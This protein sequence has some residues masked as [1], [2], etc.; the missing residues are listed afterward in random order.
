MLSIVRRSSF[1]YVTHF[2]TFSVMPLYIVIAGRSRTIVF[3][4]LLAV[5]W[6]CSSVLWSERNE[7]YAF[8]RMLPVSDRDVARAKLGLGLGAAFVYW[9]W[10]SLLSLIVAGATPEFL[11]RF[12][13]IN[14]AAS[15]WPPLVALCYLG[16]WRRGA[17]A[18][19]FPLVTL[20]AVF[21]IVAVGVAVRFFPSGRGGNLG[22][23]PA[24]WPLQVLLPATGLVAF[25][26]LA[27]LAPR[28]KLDNDEHL[29]LP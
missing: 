2:L 12:S 25:L 10:L 27:R 15:A 4:I 18:M 1:F 11:A 8:L 21:F 16:V 29:Q 14:L 22:L 9:A 17:R 28:V 13:L 24:P 23:A 7:S 26:L 19:T 3:M 5:V 6:L 20:I